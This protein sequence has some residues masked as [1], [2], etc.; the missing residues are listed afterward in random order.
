MRIVRAHLLAGQFVQAANYASRAERAA[1]TLPP[2]EA[3]ASYLAGVAGLAALVSRTYRNAAR[4][5]CNVRLPPSQDD[6]PASV[7]VSADKKAAAAADDDDDDADV[8]D[9][10][11]Q[12]AAA[13]ESAKV[14]AA[15]S[16]AP[17]DGAVA[18]TVTRGVFM[19]EVMT[20][21]D[22]AL[23]A[24]LS[25]LAALD[26]GE[27]KRRVLDNEAFSAVLS[28]MPE[29][30]LL[31]EDFVASRYASL[32][33]R[34]GKLRPRMQLDSVLA[35]L[36]AELEVTIR[37]KALKQYF[38]PY[39]SVDLT[40]MAAAFACDVEQ[41]EDELAQLIADDHIQARIDS[42]NKRLFARQSDERAD[43]F[44]AVINAG[45]AYVR[46][47]QALLLKLNLGKLEL[48]V[49]VTPRNLPME[50]GERG[51]RE[52]PHKMRDKR[53]K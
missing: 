22:V 1:E 34:L 50:R 30:R 39:S 27:V 18:D 33:E 10:K 52:L 51:D 5:L 8:D 53:R 29:A 21:S 24:T 23:Y 40:R 20:G 47:M 28:T 2:S 36:A 13:K 12:K 44:A 11:P 41:L 14:P 43:T 32:F 4:D 6:A 46:N 38:G 16:D 9:K 15:L 35:P 48:S 45:E 25:A 19:P 49:R 31:L 37:Q 26:R 7:S 3:R 17:G 42:H